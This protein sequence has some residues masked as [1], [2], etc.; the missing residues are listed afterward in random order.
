MLPWKRRTAVPASG[1]AVTVERVSKTFGDTHAVIDVSF[2]VERGQIFG[3]IGPSGSGK[4]TMVRMITGVQPPDQGR[5]VVLGR[6]PRNFDAATRERIGYMPQHFLLYPELSVRENLNFAAYCYGVPL[7]GRSDRL[8]RMLDFVELSD[9][10]DSQAG[11]ISGGMQRRLELACTLIHEPEVIVVDEP[12]AGVDPVLRQKF[13]DHFRELRDQGRTLL[14]TTQYV[15][16]S[17]YCDIVAAMKAGRVVARGTPDAVRQSAM[18][19]EIV[20]V[21]ASGLT[22]AAV[23]EL[24]RLPGVRRVRILGPDELSVTVESAGAAT[25]QLLATLQRAGATVANVS[26]YRPNFDEVFVRL[27]EAQSSDTPLP[28]DAGLTHRQAA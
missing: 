9:A 10:R 17:E 2:Q 18:G 23:A 27:M 25:P 5:V 24:E 3:L 28:T 11:S 19:G 13:W 7:R 14:V 22:R 26:E 8:R 16:E 15:T 21:T 6:E 4:T 20:N 1:D 12:T